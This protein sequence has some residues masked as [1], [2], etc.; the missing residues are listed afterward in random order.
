MTNTIKRLINYI[1]KDLFFFLIIFILIISSVI[2]SLYIPILIGRCFDDIKN[3]ND[4]DFNSLYQNITK[5]FICVVINGFIMYFIELINI[6]I[7]NKITNNIRKDCFSKLFRVPFS[8]L[9][10][11]NKG[12]TL[13]IIINDIDTFSLGMLSGFKE[14]C[15]GIFM[16]IGTIIFMMI[17]NPIIALVVIVITPLSLL[18]SRFISSKTY[19]L[20]KQLALSKEVATS[21]IDERITNLYVSINY[22]YEEKNIEEFNIINKDLTNKSFKAVF[23]SSLTNP[24]TRFVNSVVYA[25]VCLFCSIFIINSGY[26]HFTL[27]I[28]SLT[29]FLSYANQYTKPFN[30]IASVITELQNAKASLERIFKM[31]DECEVDDNYSI[32]EYKAIGNVYLDNISFSY[33]INKPLLKNIT[34]S[35]KQGEK[36]AIVGPSGCGKTTLINLLMRFYDTSSGCIYIDNNKITDLSLKTLRDNFGMVLQDTWIRNDTVANN[37]RFGNPKASLQEVINASVATKADSFIR[38]LSNGYDTKIS[39]DSGLSNGEKQLICITRVMLINPSMLILDEATSSIDTL[40]EVKIQEAFNILMQGR[41]T[42]IVAHR[43]STIKNSDKILVMKDGNI[44]E[45]GNHIELLEKKGFYYTLYNS[46]F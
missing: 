25:F 44:V 32:K 6:I 38:R 21:F 26:F 40:T 18:S 41:T 27:S 43:L 33:N 1:K 12:K 37:I 29:T 10:N 42:F 11:N 5:I 2:L 20:S 46:R 15:N 13:S 45:I 9:D 28:S 17:I 14:F 23:F 4:V 35:F 39:D 31:L 16:I 24:T 3:I 7:S 22:N 30:E 19:K 36:I 34:A 8:Y